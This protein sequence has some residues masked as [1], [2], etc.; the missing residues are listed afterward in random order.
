MFPP[1]CSSP[2]W[3]NM[4]V[5]TVATVEMLLGSCGPHA[6]AVPWLTRSQC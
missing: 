4:L 6:T 1:R 2:A 5:K 3:L